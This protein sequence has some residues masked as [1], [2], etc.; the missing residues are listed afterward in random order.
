MSGETLHKKRYALLDVLMRILVERQNARGLRKNGSCHR[1]AEQELTSLSGRA[2]CV[3]DDHIK[4]ADNGRGLCRV[5]D[6]PP[7]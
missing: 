1:E 7:K 4:W 5:F 3:L 6:E 2:Q